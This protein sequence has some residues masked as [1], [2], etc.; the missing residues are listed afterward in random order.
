MS[1]LV[2]RSAA[3][4]LATALLFGTVSNAFATVWTDQPDYAPG[5]VVTI[6]GDNSNGAGYLAGE[7]VHVDVS[8]PNGYAST[9]EGVADAN[10]AWSCQVTLWDSAL[11]GGDYAYTATGLTSGVTE[12][13]TFTDVPTTQVDTLLTLSLSSS[14][15]A[16]G[17]STTLSGTLVADPADGDSAANPVPV[18]RTVDI[19]RY[20]NSG[21]TGSA[22][23]INAAT[24]GAG[25]AYSY[26]Y[27]PASAGTQ[28]I[29]AHFAQYSPGT[30]TWK[31]S[32]SP[33]R[34]LVIDAAPS[35][36][37]TTPADGDTGV[38]TNSDV[39][40]TFNEAV[41]AAAGWYDITCGSSGNHTAVQSGGPTTFTLNPIAD[42][43]PGET[44]TVTVYA[45]DITDND[46]T[47]P[48][49]NMAADYVFSFD[50]DAAPSVSST[51]PADGATGVATN[52]DISLTFSEKVHGTDGWYDITCTSSGTHT[53]V[54][55]GGPTTYTLNPDVDF[56]PGE[57]CTVT[58]YAANVSDNDTDD[59]PQHMVA[60]YVF[61]FTVASTAVTPTLTTE[62]RDASDDSPGTS[63]AF[64]TSVYDHA[65]VDSGAEGSIGFELFKGSNCT[66]L[67]GV[68]VASGSVGLV[69]GTADSGAS[70]ALTDDTY[71]FVV[72]YTSSDTDQWLD[73][74]TCEEFSVSAA[75]VTPTFT[76]AVHDSADDSTGTSFPLGTEVYDQLTAVDPSDAEGQVSFELW[77]GG[78]CTSLGGTLISDSGPFN[79][80]AT[81]PLDSDTYFALHADS[82]YIAVVF[83]TA[84]SAQWTNATGCEEF[85]I[86]PADTTTTTVV[87]DAAH[88]PITTTA[89]G[90]VHDSATV[91][92]DGYAGF[93]LDPIPSNVHFTL[94]DNSSCDGNVLQTDGKLA[95]GTPPQTVE[96]T[97][98]TAVVGSYSFKVTY[99]GNSDYNGSTSD[100]ESFAV[101]PPNTISDLSDV[102]AWVGLKNSDDQG[103]NFDLKV[104]L[105]D[106]STL[107]A[108][109]LQR[110]VTGLTRNATLARDV[111]I[112]WGPF[113]P[114]TVNSGETLSLKLS[115]RIG[116]TLGGARCGAPASH[117]NARGI[118]LYYDALSRP[119]RFDA[120]IGG[121]NSDYYLR[122]DGNACGQTE[123]TGVT[124]RYLSQ[125]A[126]SA[127][128]A[129]CKDS[130]GINFLFGN[131]WQEIGTWYYTLP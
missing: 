116:T 13:G 19:S 67:A 106:G 11:A 112:T 77:Q 31:A 21:C 74:S 117:S 102:H 108:S 131:V 83:E 64:G 75:A 38:Q 27:T 111:A 71:Y 29:Q 32:D 90:D 4:A 45:A 125:T 119:S 48:P 68:S 114:F 52:A 73:T 82:Y 36:S 96:S 6:S 1:H 47:D 17:G 126:P 46:T 54:A 18:G 55:S 99:D 14:A 87:H 85:T 33:C 9:C 107:V 78:D 44:C 110:C 5:S 51:T 22:T 109:G 104:E 98:Y 8:G 95:S 53:A 94:Y 127:T 115:T 70:G 63:F 121:A 80:P 20:P 60:D 79:L 91:D 10:G 34:T 118:R 7:T 62:V 97:P 66:D 23:L 122:S 69:S 130:A 15:I 39:S 113:A 92:T 12:S 86:D 124:T 103:T 49:D 16:F 89:P 81:L 35:V 93:D 26:L 25:G 59:P 41:T 61:S 76:T 105:Y 50:T 120:T 37:S 43:A 101:A 40:I 2:R 3:V 28:Y 84:D 129:K 123:S 72:D 65:S 58:I 56:D 88:N 24:T 30:V 42:F 57:T 128:A 100:C